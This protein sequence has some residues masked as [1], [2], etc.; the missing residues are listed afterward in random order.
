V[1]DDDEDEAI[2]TNPISADNILYVKTRDGKIA[3]ITQP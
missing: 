3:A 2:Y 1:G